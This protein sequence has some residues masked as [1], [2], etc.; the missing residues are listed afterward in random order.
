MKKNQNKINISIFSGG[1]GNIEL[2][3]SLKKL[4]FVE[5]KILSNCYDDGKSTGDLREIM[6]GI[7]GPS[8]I[9]KNIS[10]L[11]NNEIIS[12]ND[13]K[14]IIDYRFK[15]IDFLDL[16]KKI[17][18]N[19]FLKENFNKINKIKYDQIINAIRIFEKKFGKLKQKFRDFS[20]GNIIFCGVYLNKKNFNKSVEEFNLIFLDKVS[21]YNI[22]NGQNLYLCGIRKNKKIIKNEE[23]LVS[24][25]GDIIENIFLIKDKSIFNKK[26]I[27]EKKLKQLDVKPKIN[28]RI[29]NIIKNSD[30]I[31]Y[32]P[33]T[34]HSSLYPTYLT[35]GLSKIIA[36]STAKKFLITNII[37]DNDIYG[38]T[39]NSLISK[40][41]YFFSN[42]KK[43][44]SPQLGLVDFYFVHKYE[45]DDLNKINDNLYIDFKKNFD[46]KKIK[47]LDWEKIKGIHF[48]GLI[49][50]EIFKCL[51]DINSLKRLNQIFTVSIIIPCLNEKK[52]VG[53]V[54]RAINNLEIK[55]NNFNLFK[56]VIVVDGGSNDGS[57]KILSKTKNIKFFKLN[58]AGRGTS[59][60]YGIKKSKGD[61]VIIFPSDN[62]YE[63][64]DIINV[65]EPIFLQQSKIVFGSRIIKC[66]NLDDR[67]SK[68]YKNNRLGFIISK[69]GGMILSTLGLFFYNRYINDTLTTFKAYDGN[70]IRKQKYIS[71]GVDF[72]IE[73][74]AKIS[75]SKNY[76][77]ETPVLYK[78]RSQSQGKKISLLDGFKCL[79]AFFRY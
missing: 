57:A 12:E 10:N 1:S 51:K 36:K 7:L 33:G 77:F 78:P 32:G 31:I 5:V 41:Y 6:G 48:P 20:L 73:Q 27:S 28:Y 34:Q 24:H 26:K 71:K 9:R 4:D 54:C 37:F 70:Y 44:T 75:K 25:R 59:I 38:E 63:V 74:L 52:T 11:L 49:V 43:N 60:Q 55:V 30:I 69:Y 50:K 19:H 62:E 8:D 39:I 61:I 67:I 64:K 58:K 29:P 14:N 40:F 47:Y 66:I 42:R 18:N 2:I 46:F 79:L 21:V 3:N 23:D 65:I 76:V 45:K 17:L 68:I 15:E 22:S 72:E 53:K 16:E 13:L 56:E 35:E